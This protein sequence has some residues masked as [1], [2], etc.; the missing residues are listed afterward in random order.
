MRQHILIALGVTAIVALSGSF[1][2]RAHSG[3]ASSR[4]RGPI[5][6]QL[7]PRP[8]F[9]VNEMKDGPLKKSLQG[10]SEMPM[11]PRTFGLRAAFSIA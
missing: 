8:Y 4:D 10:C 1:S 6:V 2:L 11:K 7:G 3:P 9:L 5:A